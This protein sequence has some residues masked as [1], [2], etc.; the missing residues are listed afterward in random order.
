MSLKCKP[1]DIAL[2]VRHWADTAP[3]ALGQFRLVKVYGPVRL[4][5]EGRSTWR[6]YPVV[7]APWIYDLT[8]GADLTCID[9]AMLPLRPEPGS[10]ERLEAVLQDILLE[11]L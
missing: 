5:A 9:D 7:M 3:W 8:S 1:G 6:V 11:T 4:D 2:I 10:E